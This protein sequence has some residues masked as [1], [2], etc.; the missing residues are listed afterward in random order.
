ML[1]ASAVVVTYVKDVPDF[2]I[3]HGF[4]CRIADC[5]VNAAAFPSQLL[6]TADT[7]IR[8][9]SCSYKDTCPIPDRCSCSCGYLRCYN[10]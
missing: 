10:L 1:A 2:S 7:V 8:Y 5:D 6:R 9:V 3:R 4:A